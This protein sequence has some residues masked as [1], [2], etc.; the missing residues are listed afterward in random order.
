MKHQSSNLNALPG[1]LS[2]E[3]LIHER[4][5]RHP[6][7]SPIRLGIETLNQ[8]NLCRRLLKQI[9]PLV[10]TIRPVCLSWPHAKRLT[11]P[12]RIDELEWHEL[13]V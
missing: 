4:T 6:P 7:R 2:L 8:H 12:V 1:P 3:L 11:H 10:A 9:V 5:M 13:I